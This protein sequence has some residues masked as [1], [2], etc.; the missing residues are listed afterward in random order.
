MYRYIIYLTVQFA[1]TFNYLE[2]GCPVINFS[3]HQVISTSNFLVLKNHQNQ[4]IL[5]FHQ[6][7]ENG[8]PNY[9]MKGPYIDL[10]RQLCEA[11]LTTQDV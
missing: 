10:A 5:S 9:I 4:T 7:K 2:N 11:S 8:C 1:Y 6:K 3:C